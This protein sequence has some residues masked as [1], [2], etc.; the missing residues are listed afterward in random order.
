[1]VF[2]EK[3]CG[4]IYYAGVWA[5]TDDRPFLN[6]YHADSQDVV[7]ESATNVLS[8]DSKEYVSINSVALRGGGAN[9]GLNVTLYF[10]ISR[11]STF[12]MKTRPF[13]WDTETG[14]SVGGAVEKI[15][16]NAIEM[17]SKIAVMKRAISFLLTTPTGKN[18]SFLCD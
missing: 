6:V 2:N 4:F 7:L 12:S 16:N 11:G 14:G 9:G 17:I 1:L 15:T 18:N 5:V 10:E 3:A 8:S 13:F